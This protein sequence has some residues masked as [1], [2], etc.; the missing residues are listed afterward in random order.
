MA[1]IGPYFGI[2]PRCHCK[3]SRNHTY[4]SMECQTYCT[5][6]C[7]IR[8]NAAKKYHDNRVGKVAFVCNDCKLP[9]VYKSQSG[10]N[11]E[12]PFCRECKIKHRIIAK[13]EAREPT[14][15]Q[16]KHCGSNFVSKSGAWTYCSET[17]S[18][19]GKRNTNRRTAREKSKLPEIAAAI[20][21][22][23]ILRRCLY[24]TQQEKA[25]RTLDVLGYTAEDLRTRIEFQFQPGMSWENRSDWHIDHKKPVTA[26]IRQGIKDPRTINSLC[27]LKP[28]WASENISKGDS[29]NG[30]RAS[31]DNLK[32]Y[33]QA[34]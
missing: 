4:G 10:R 19:V 28:M 7:R 30:R 14:V 8:F 20:S 33:Q 26:F 5:E 13:S 9:V 6:E 2:C 15:R 12:A 34:A 21:A 23:K 11:P 27:N 1:V 18:V 31:N 22:R 29:W 32:Q 25:G 16:C 3:F 17:C 24:L